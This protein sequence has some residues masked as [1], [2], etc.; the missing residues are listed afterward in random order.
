M[1][2]RLGEGKRA[3]S[4][5]NEPS[6]VEARSHRGRQIVG[7]LDDALYSPN[8]CCHPN[9]HARMENDPRSFFVR[10]LTLPHVQSFI[11]RGTPRVSLLSDRAPHWTLPSSLLRGIQLT[12]RRGFSS[13]APFATFIVAPIFPLYAPFPKL[14]SICQ[15]PYMGSYI[16]SHGCM[17]TS[18]AIRLRQGGD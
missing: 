16:G 12:R 1:V 15:L 6:S 11:F 13:F 4:T 2:I 17:R 8:E 9:S 5:Q 14:D 10:I 18:D 7:L 3:T